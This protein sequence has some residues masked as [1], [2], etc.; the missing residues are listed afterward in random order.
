MV[1]FDFKL[2]CFCI[3]TFLLMQSYNFTCNVINL[4]LILHFYQ[5]VIWV[6]NSFYSIWL[7]MLVAFFAMAPIPV[8]CLEQSKKCIWHRPSR[9]WS[10]QA[11]LQKSLKPSNVSLQKCFFFV[12]VSRHKSSKPSNFSPPRF[13]LS[14]SLDHTKSIQLLGPPTSPTFQLKAATKLHFQPD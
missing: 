11:G 3:H 12:T 2:A 14:Q 6:P 5:L 7:I 8:L 9:G 4:K 1:I 10:N 13:F